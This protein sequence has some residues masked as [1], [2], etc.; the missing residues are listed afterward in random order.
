MFTYGLYNSGIKYWQD[1]AFNIINYLIYRQGGVMKDT[2]FVISANTGMTVNTSEGFGMVAMDSNISTFWK[3]LNWVLSD[4]IKTLTIATADATN[5]RYDLVC[6]KIDTANKTVS[7]VSSGDDILMKGTPAGSPSAPAVPAGYTQVGYILVTA[8]LTT[9]TS[10]NIF[11][12]RSVLQPI[13]QGVQQNI[14][15]KILSTG[16]KVGANAD[17]NLTY[18][19]ST[20]QGIVNG[21][22][23]VWQRGTSFALTSQV[24]YT[25]DRWEAYR[26]AFAGGA[27]VSRRDGSGGSPRAE[28]CA[29]V[30]RNNGNTAV[31]AI[32]FG[33]SMTTQESFKYR[34]RPVSFSFRARKGS[35]FS[36]V[37]SNILINLITGTGTDQ[38]MRVG[39][40][41]QTAILSTSV[42][43][44][45]SW[46]LFTFTTGATL[47]GN[48]IRQ[49]GLRFGYDPAGTAGA[50]DYFEIEEVQMNPG[51][52][53]L[54][55]MDSNYATELAI[56][57]RSFRRVGTGMVGRWHL[58][59]ACE[60]SYVFDSPM[61]TSPNI[62]HNTSVPVI[63]EMGIGPRTGSG[64]AASISFVS[65]TGFSAVVNGFSGATV[66][67]MAC[68]TT[69]IFDCDASM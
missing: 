62:V 37:S 25:A 2:D 64:S 43:L 52:E 24:Y 41:G 48:S 1:D 34:G 63:N 49:I 57:R 56:C 14:E 11:N 69:D 23:S 6:L 20:R 13:L 8:G 33:N 3:T 59:T 40:T 30:Q 12:I 38:N 39:Y 46:Q 66:G 27:T 50:N 54:P 58:T 67:V 55:F 65:P 31:D 36:A 9:I 47:I 60:V 26:S 35:N 32:F 19:G 44:T 17:G 42:T 61:R 4:E 10:A 15:N 22:F 51:T 16:V 21:G 53:V 18:E 68:P 29:R 28:Y 7:L 45:T 5:P